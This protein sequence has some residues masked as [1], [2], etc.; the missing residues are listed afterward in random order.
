MSGQDVGISKLLGSGTAPGVGVGGL[1]GFL[2]EYC[3]WNVENCGRGFCAPGVG[4]GWISLTLDGTTW[5][6]CR[7]WPRTAADGPGPVPRGCLSDADL[8][9]RCG[10]GMSV[11]LGEGGLGVKADCVGDR[12]GA[13][14]GDGGLNVGTGPFPEDDT[15]GL[16]ANA[17]FNVLGRI[18]LWR[19]VGTEAFV[20]V[21]TG[22]CFSPPAV[23]G[24]L[25]GEVSLRCVGLFSGG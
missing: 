22:H 9:G 15:L 2:G 12:N 21:V 14:R 6:R 24:S 20:A 5:L 13:L 23:C 10:G 4:S 7:A 17:T 3:C 16:V 19:R 1:V 25:F 11:F 8:A 18:R